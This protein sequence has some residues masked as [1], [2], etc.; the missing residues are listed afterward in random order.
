MKKKKKGTKQNASPQKTKQEGSKKNAW[1]I[2]LIITLFAAWITTGY[3]IFTINLVD[4][5]KEREAHQNKI[6]DLLP[7]WE[8]LD[9]DCGNYVFYLDKDR[10]SEK[11]RHDFFWAHFMDILACADSMVNNTIK[12]EPFLRHDEFGEIVNNNAR[13]IYHRQALNY[14]YNPSKDNAE[15]IANNIKL[16]YKKYLFSVGLEEK[17]IKGN[18]EF[19]GQID[20]LALMLYNLYNSTHKNVDSSNKWFNKFSGYY[21]TSPISVS[22]VIDKITKEKNIEAMKIFEIAYDYGI[23][24]PMIKNWKIIEKMIHPYFYNNFKIPC[25][26]L[27]ISYNFIWQIILSVLIFFICGRFIWHFIKRLDEKTTK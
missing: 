25:M 7:F 20:E 8:K 3:N 14:I 27:Y 21:N 23:I 10:V 26:D 24:T 6:R 4:I 1:L 11:Q 22:D 2:S 16:A 19:L 18:N 9:K 5:N 17:N 12:M 13:I 15:D